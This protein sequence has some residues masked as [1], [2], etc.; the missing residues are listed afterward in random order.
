[1][2]LCLRITFRADVKEG[3]LRTFVLKHAKKCGVEGTAR[4]I[5]DG[6]ILVIVCGSKE[7]VDDF[8]DE[9]HAG[10]IK[11]NIDDVQLEPFLKSRDYRG[12]FRV[13]E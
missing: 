9:L 6:K 1:M 8:V 3:F 7:N 2:S 10:A 4:F 5:E 12:A 13:I 11:H